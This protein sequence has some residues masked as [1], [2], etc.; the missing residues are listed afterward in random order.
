MTFERVSARIHPS[1][2]EKLSKT[3]YNARQAI[4]YFNS[5]S[6][7]EVDQLSIEEYF[8][9]KEIED[10]KYDLISKEAKLEDIQK[11]KDEIY[12][13]NLSQLRIQSYQKII[14]MYTDVDDKTSVT[15]QAFEEFIEMRFIEN[16]IVRE[17]ASVQCPL[18]EYKE[19]LLNYYN[20][21]ILV[22][23]TID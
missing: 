11:R 4:E 15:T 12:K 8:L 23:R 5:V 19:G 2:K 18:D 16:T 6:C 7:N 3:G 17:L 1:D 13:G 21:V 20:D 14:G 10:M 22:G 9:N